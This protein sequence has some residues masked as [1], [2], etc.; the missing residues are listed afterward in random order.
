[1]IKHQHDA[2]ENAMI[3]AMPSS[4]SPLPDPALPS[5][6]QPYWLKRGVIACLLWPASL[7]FCIISKIRR[8]WLT[9]FRKPWRANVPIVIVGNL[10]AGGAGKTPTAIA[11]IEFLLKNGHQPALVSRGYGRERPIAC[12]EVLPNSTPTEVGDEPLLIKRRTGIPIFVAT[13]RTKAVVNA[14][15]KYPQTSVI[16]S[17]DGLQHYALARDIEIIVFDER[18]T[19]NGW[20][21]PAGLL[22]EPLSRAKSADLII[23]NAPSP[24]LPLPGFMAQRSLGGYLPLNTWLEQQ[25]T[26]RNDEN[27]QTLSSIPW[28]P[29]NDMVE[30]QKLQATRISAVAGIGSP[31]RF[32]DMLNNT[33]L[34]LERTLALPDHYDYPQDSFDTIDSDIILITEKDAAKCM[35]F[36]NDTRLYVVTL[37][38]TLNDEFFKQFE[39]LLEKHHPISEAKQTHG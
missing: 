38:Y 27:G 11:L 10:T 32:F 13:K 5:A 23:Y 7:L 18:G 30:Q 1:M 6:P 35:P 3:I 22:R 26:Y 14:L 28:L 39:H 36:K 33:G 21:L 17:D 24:S 12:V 31:Q 19:G 29:M 37:T 25:A 2:Y 9:S 15:E 16:I 20:L 34:M 4:K 8:W